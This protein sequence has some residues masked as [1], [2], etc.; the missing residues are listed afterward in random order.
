MTSLSYLYVY[1]NLDV[2]KDSMSTHS[3]RCFMYHYI[4]SWQTRLNKQK[5]SHL[6]ILPTKL[7]LIINNATLVWIIW[8]TEFL[9]IFF[10]ILWFYFSWL[11]IF[12]GWL[13]PEKNRIYKNRIKEILSFCL[14]NNLY[15]VEGGVQSNELMA[16]NISVISRNRCNFA[17]NGKVGKHAFCAGFKTGGRDTC[18]VWLLIKKI[19]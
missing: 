17:Y 11:G 8:L 19:Q 14:Y 2:F 3:I 4:Y 12:V 13:L 16:T 18:Q 10:L 6:F 9:I 7:F 1:F 5:N 15:R